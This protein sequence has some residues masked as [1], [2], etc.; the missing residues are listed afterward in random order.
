MKQKL[1]FRWIGGGFKKTPEANKIHGKKIL[2]TSEENE[3][4][5]E[6]AMCYQKL[7]MGNTAQEVL[8]FLCLHEQCP[9]KV[10]VEFHLYFNTLLPNFI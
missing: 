7:Q 6:S 9:P 4:E 10:K 8:D 1:G 2:R 5:T 3:K